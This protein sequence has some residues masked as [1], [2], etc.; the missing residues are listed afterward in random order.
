M[1]PQGSA[2]KGTVISVPLQIA[3]R[4]GVAGS[5]VLESPEALAAPLPAAQQVVRAASHKMQKSAGCW[6]PPRHVLAAWEQGWLSGV[7]KEGT[8]SCT[9]GSLHPW[10]AA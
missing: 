2:L 6:L 8:H 10:L 4:P 9:V 5:S 1:W 7:T 3:Q